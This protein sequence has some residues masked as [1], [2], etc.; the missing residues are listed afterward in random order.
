[1]CGSDPDK[2]SFILFCHPRPGSGIHD[3]DD[4]TRGSTQRVHPWPKASF[5]DGAAFAGMTK[6]YFENSFRARGLFFCTPL[7]PYPPYF[8]ILSVT[9]DKIV[10][11][12]YSMTVD[13]SRGHPIHLRPDGFGGQAGERRRESRRSNAFKRTCV[14]C[15]YSSIF[16]VFLSK[17]GTSFL[18]RKTTARFR[19]S[20]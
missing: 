3:V 12:C 4:P 14:F 16:E 5:W 10:K 20:S 11:G 13:N 7:R 9:L 15:R 17:I 2:R 6:N 18:Y 1:M 8:P 19:Q